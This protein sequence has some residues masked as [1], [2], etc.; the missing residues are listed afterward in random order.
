MKLIKR[1]KK[2]NEAEGIELDFDTFKD[3]LSEISDEYEHIFSDLSS[4]NDMPYY[5]LKIILPE[6]SQIDDNDIYFN[7]NYLHDFIPP[8]EEPVDS[9]DLLGGENLV[10]QSI[11]YQISQYYKL[12]NELESMIRISEKMKLIFDT[13]EKEVIPRFKQFNNFQ[14]CTL[15]FDG[16]SLNITFDMFE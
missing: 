2:F 3:I 6:L 12:K 10:N 15:G 4:S 14:H 5:D 11:E 7:W 9:E 8:S 13:L 16:E 1:W